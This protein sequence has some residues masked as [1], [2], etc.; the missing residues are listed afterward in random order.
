MDE[1]NLEKNKN[2]IKNW[3]KLGVLAIKAD[4]EHANGRRHVGK[5][6]AL[7]W[8]WVESKLNPPVKENALILQPNFYGIGVNLRSAY[9][10]IL[11][12]FKKN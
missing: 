7:A 1:L 6:Q 9:K 5:H 4:L 10:I 3:E 11:G 2:R 12:W 8:K